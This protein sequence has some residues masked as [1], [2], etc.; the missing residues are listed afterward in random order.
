[1]KIK[2]SNLIIFIF[3]MNIFFNIQNIKSMNMQA[4]NIL[5]SIEEYLREYK[6]LQ[7]ERNVDTKRIFNS[8]DLDV[9]ISKKM[10]ENHNNSIIEEKQ[11]KKGEN[12]NIFNIFMYFINPLYRTKVDK[13]LEE[14]TTK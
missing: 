1:M 6:K 11:Y 4:N 8:F 14:I 5:Y 7:N 10:E 3:L 12:N 13:I 2:T 9:N